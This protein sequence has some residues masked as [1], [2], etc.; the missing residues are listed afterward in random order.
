MLKRKTLDILYKITFRSVIDYSLP[1][2]GNSVKQKDLA[3]LE[4]LQYSAAKLVTGALHQ[5]SREKLNIELGWENMKTRIQFLGLSIFQ[6]IH[7]HET[8]SLVRS[9]MS[10]LDTQKQYITRSK[11]GYLPYP[12]YGVKFLNSYFPYISKLWNNL[13]IS[14]KRLGLQEFKDKLKEKLKP[15]R[16]KHHSYG[17]KIGNTLLTRIRLDRSDLNLHKFIIGQADS[18]Q[19]D[20]LAKKES[21]LHFLVDC[22]LYS[23]ERQTLYSQVEYYIPNFQTLNKTR[24][25][26]ILVFGLHPENNEYNYTNMKISFAVQNFIL[27]T[28]RFSEKLI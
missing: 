5:T 27:K 20:C 10:K 19:C 25:Y 28:K 26:E 6:K 13:E 22:F 8:R 9:C 11:G 12:N 24:K 4:R 14:T 15:I 17:S 18:P 21:S 2:Y 1:I 3:R 7:V 23:N 16:V